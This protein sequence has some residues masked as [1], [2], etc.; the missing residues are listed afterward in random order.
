MAEQDSI[1]EKNQNW[2]WLANLLSQVFWPLDGFIKTLEEYDANEDLMAVLIPLIDRAK[3]DLEI[4]DEVLT[5]SFGGPIKI[6]TAWDKKNFR[7]F[8]QDYFGKALIDSIPAPEP[9]DSPIS[10]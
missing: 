9:L 4:L 6:E 5:Q 2:E 3:S 7:A 8:K 10:T 1:T